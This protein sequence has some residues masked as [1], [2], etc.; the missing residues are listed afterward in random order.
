MGLVV[1]EVGLVVVEMRLVVVEMGLVVT[2]TPN[3]VSTKQAL[4]DIGTYMLV[5]KRKIMCQNNTDYPLF[6]LIPFDFPKFY[7]KNTVFNKTKRS[8]L[9]FYYTVQSVGVLGERHS[10]LAEGVFLTVNHI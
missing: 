2:V 7:T 4:V 3:S 6:G 5:A 9:L 8:N 1:A 10:P